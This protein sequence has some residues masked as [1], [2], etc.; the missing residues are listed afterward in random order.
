MKQKEEGEEGEGEKKVLS[1]SRADG[2]MCSAHFK[3]I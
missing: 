2:M 1:I 3:M